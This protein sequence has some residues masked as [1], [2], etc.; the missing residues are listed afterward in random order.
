MKI[1]TDTKYLPIYKAL[2][3]NVR[4]TIIQL[5]S[6]QPM[7][8]K[9]LAETLDLSSAIIT[10]HV[11][12]LE[13]AGII[14]CETLSLNGGRQKLCSL[15][16]NHIEIAFPKIT[17]LLHEQRYHFDLPVGHY[18]KIDV[19]PTCGLASLD[20]IIGQLDSTQ[21]FLEPERMDARILWFSEGYV[22]YLLPNY[23]LK[24]QRLTGLCISM[25]IG[26]EYPGVN[27]NW[28]SEITFSVAGTEVGSWL[29]PGDFGTKRGKLNPIWWDTILNQYGSLKVLN[30]LERGT[31]IDG[32]KISDV[33]VSDLDL[34]QEKIKLCIGVKDEARY[35]GGVTIFGAGFGN[36][37]QNILVDLYY[38]DE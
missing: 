1:T 6:K 19:K 29:S 31:F 4:L 12:K 36:Y 7:N 28:P 2:A 18:T 37:D 11:K 22:E 24:G 8:I 38:T 3:S 17:D 34:S 27:D 25:E 20:K 33:T 10:M 23:L 5:L 13:E 9:D 15:E 26:S 30:I 16:T 14:R 35:K 21:C 32:E